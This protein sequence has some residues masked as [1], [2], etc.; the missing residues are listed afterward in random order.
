MMLSITVVLPLH[1]WSHF[2]MCATFTIST[3]LKFML[4][5]KLIIT[6]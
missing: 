2:S 4:L 5:I 3:K 1:C 6:F